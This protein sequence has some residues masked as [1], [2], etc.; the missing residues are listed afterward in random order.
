MRTLRKG[1]IVGQPSWDAKHASWIGKMKRIG[2]GVDMT[3]VCAL[4]E[5]ILTITVVTVYGTPEK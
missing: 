3:V 2:T 1:Q 5:G 4:Q